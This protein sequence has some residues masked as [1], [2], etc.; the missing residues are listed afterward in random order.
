MHQI[1]QNYCSNPFLKT[2]A[3]AGSTIVFVYAILNVIVNANVIVVEVVI[4][5]VNVI[6]ISCRHFEVTPTP[7]HFEVTPIPCFDFEMLKMSYS[8][9]QVAQQRLADICYSDFELMFVAC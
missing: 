4:V 9:L 7:R 3:I 6:A 1:S 5:L 8:V 2:L